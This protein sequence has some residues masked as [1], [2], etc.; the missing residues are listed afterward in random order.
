M[1]AHH[2]PHHPPQEAVAGDLDAQRRTRPSDQRAARHAAHGVGVALRQVGELRKVVLA[3]ERGRGL[4]A[5][6]RAAA[7]SSADGMRVTAADAAVATCWCEI[8][9]L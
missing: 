7:L 9:S 3:L 5:A 4:P 1:R 6:A 8:T 2:V